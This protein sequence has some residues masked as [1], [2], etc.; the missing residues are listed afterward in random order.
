MH[1]PSNLTYLV[2]SIINCTSVQVLEGRLYEC[3]C[4]CTIDWKKAYCLYQVSI[5]L[6]IWQRSMI[7]RIDRLAVISFS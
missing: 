4:I 1:T 2:Y 7:P 5:N 6:F 3:L